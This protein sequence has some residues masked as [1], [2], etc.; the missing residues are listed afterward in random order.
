MLIFVFLLI[1]FFCLTFLEK[2]QEEM[3]SL[4][5]QGKQAGGNAGDAYGEG[6]WNEGCFL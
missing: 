5:G 6:V 2:S 1:A 4:S 3:M